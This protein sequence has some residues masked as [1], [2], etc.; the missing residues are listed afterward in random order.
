MT[1][2]PH[3]PD[4]PRCIDDLYIR[5]LGPLLNGQHSDHSEEKPK[6]KF[7]HVTLAPNISSNAA[8]T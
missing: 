7:H 5:R 1:Y 2:D 3:P 6:K 8:A 4:Q